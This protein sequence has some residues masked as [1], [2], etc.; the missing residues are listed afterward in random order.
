MRDKIV[1]FEFKLDK[2]AEA[3]ISQIKEKNY[4]QIYKHKRIPIYLAGINFN[5]E[6]RTMDDWRVEMVT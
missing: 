6:L 4:F 2:T 3:A 5:S 1:I